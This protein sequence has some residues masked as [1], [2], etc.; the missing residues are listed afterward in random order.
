M[1]PPAINTALVSWARANSFPKVTEVSSTRNSFVLTSVTTTSFVRSFGC[2]RYRV[3]PVF[4][5]LRGDLPRD[6]LIRE[7]VEK[8]EPLSMPHLRSSPLALPRCEEGVRARAERGGRGAGGGGGESGFTGLSVARGE[9]GRLEASL[10]PT[11]LVNNSSD[12]SRS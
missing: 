1:L 4:R 7:V 11:P 8:S 2:T 5:T 10:P 12:F 3:N 6:L 9:N